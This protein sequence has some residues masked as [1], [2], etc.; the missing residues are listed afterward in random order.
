[1][2]RTH[3]RV[4]DDAL[5]HSDHGSQYTSAAFTAYCTEAGM[6]QS[7]GRTGV[8]WDNAVAETFFASLK[9]KC[10]TSMSLLPGSGHAWPWPNMSKYFTTANDRIPAWTTAPQAGLGP[11]TTTSPHR[12]QTKRPKP[13][14]KPQ[15][16]VPKT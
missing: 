9:T 2:A 1:M 7:M 6:L 3:G 4:A 12:H 13:K 10:T 8:C 14:R 15:R 5:L 16:A 11:I